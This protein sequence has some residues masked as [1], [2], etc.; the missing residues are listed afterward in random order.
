MQRILR[1][2]GL[3]TLVLAATLLAGCT[4]T[5]LMDNQVQTFSNP[6]VITTPATFRYE[7][8]PSQQVLPGQPQVEAW[9]DP[10][11]YAA[12]LR[13]DDAAPRYS[14][15][16]SARIQRILSPYADPWD[17]P[18]GWGGVGGWGGRGGWGVGVGMPLG[19]MDSPWFQREVAV[20]IRELPSNRVI[21][22]THASN[23]GPFL[24]HNVAMPAMFSA[25]MQGFPN[26]PQG[27]RRVDVQLGGA[28]APAA[29]A[30]P[31]A[32]APGSPTP[33]R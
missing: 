23:Q 2:A 5:Y 21:Y 20:Y 13:R 27:P 28:P 31:T 12:G 17:S 10:A 19:R 33:V 14:I 32:P 9:A 4:G 6:G 30:A 8:L 11:L 18:F 25:A 16:V 15:Q 24:D 26:P 22:E 1:T 29:P 3:A 7:R